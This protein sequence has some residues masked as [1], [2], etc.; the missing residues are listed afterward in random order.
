[1]EF[2]SVNPS[3][4]VLNMVEIDGT[5]LEVAVTLPSSPMFMSTISGRMGAQSSI[6][7]SRDT[8]AQSMA[9]LVER[10]VTMNLALVLRMKRSSRIVN[11]K[12]SSIITRSMIRTKKMNELMLRKNGLMLNPPSA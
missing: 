4:S 6:I 7:T 9:V 5:V 10:L 1:M 12:L 8:A 3:G 2:T 11:T